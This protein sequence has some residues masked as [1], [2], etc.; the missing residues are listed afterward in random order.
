MNRQVH[1]D[2]N[3]IIA[4]SVDTSSLGKLLIYHY[5][6]SKGIPR[7]FVRLVSLVNYIL[8][9]I[10]N[11]LHKVYNYCLYYYVN[12]PPYTIIADDIILSPKTKLS[13]FY[14]SFTSATHLFYSSLNP[15]VNFEALDILISQSLIL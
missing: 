4:F 1:L 3:V 12:A 13:L 2:L 7:N 9:S 15:K 11:D 6:I 14:K 10:K 5:Y 8:L